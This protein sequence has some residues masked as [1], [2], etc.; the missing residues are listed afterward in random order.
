VGNRN[1]AGKKA[2]KTLLPG[3]GNRG[4]SEKQRQLRDQYAAGVSGVDAYP[5]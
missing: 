1:N 5:Q 3:K 4:C 2:K